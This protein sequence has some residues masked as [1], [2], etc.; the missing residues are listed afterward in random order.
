[1][2]YSNV[3]NTTDTLGIGSRAPDFRLTAVNTNKT[4][5]LAELI[6]DSPVILEFMRGTWCPNCRK[7]MS[8]LE[9]LKDDI[10]SAGANLVYIAAEKRGGMWNPEKFFESHPITYP[11]LLDE[12]REVIKAYGLYHRIAVD[13]LDIAHPATVIVDREGRVRYIY[14]S[15]TQSDRS[16]MGEIFNALERL[17]A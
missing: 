14:K 8:E 16:P 5:S 12:D 1:M 3:Q 2:T 6:A 11:F 7:R 4:Y 17:K 13:A 15:H 10:K 9:M